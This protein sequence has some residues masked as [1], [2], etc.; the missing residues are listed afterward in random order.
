MLNTLARRTI[1]LLRREITTVRR[2]GVT[3]RPLHERA[4]KRRR[5]GDA[6]FSRVDPVVTKLDSP[7]FRSIFS[8]ELQIL[9]GLFRKHNYELRIAGGAVRDIL[10]SVQP[11]DLDFATDATPQQMKE[12]FTEEGVRM[13]NEK[14]EKH[15]TITARIN[16]AENFEITTLRIDV[17]TDGRHAQVEF[18]KDWKLDANRRDL[19]INSMFL[20]LDGRVYD[21]FYGYDDLK[22]RRVVFVGDAGVR[23]CEDYLRILRYFRFYGRIMD[24]PDEHDEATLRALKGNIDGLQQISGER[25]WSEWN[26]ILSGNF[27]PELTLKL[28]ECGAA[29]HI[30]LPEEP[31]VENF[32]NVCERARSNNVALKPISLIVSMLRDQR[33]VIKL[34]ERLKLSRYDRDLAFFL[35]QHRGCEPC[36][37]SLKPY[38][39]LV[40]LQQTARYSIL[41]D[42]V[43]ELLRYHGAMQLLDEFERWTIPKF[44]VN[45]DMLKSVPIHQMIGSVLGQLKKIWI[46]ADFK[47]TGEQLME[48]V[49]GI[50]G[51]LE[52][53]YQALGKERK[54]KLKTGK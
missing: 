34:Y 25:I 42:Y 37:S 23:I 1:S 48:H 53:K 27:A 13:I 19:T 3:S 29:R 24:S 45:G 12:M 20:D 32:R 22:K 52:E 30:G 36:G 16:N 35:V 31:D 4:W 9:A 8:P 14:G 43:K 40:L 47:L 46:D 50:V 21:Y 11:K 10:T 18:T 39:Q 7:E 33:D 49:P 2:C 51:E 54:K 6:A 26:K 44:P 28:L 38:Q 17:L 5:M 41:Q 15:G